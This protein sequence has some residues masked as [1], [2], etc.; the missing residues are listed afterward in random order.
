MLNQI[1]AFEQALRV[2]RNASAHTVRNYVSDVRQFNAFLVAHQLCGGDERGV[3]V[4][5]LDQMAV[6]AFLVDLLRRNRKSSAGRKLSAVKTFCRF[7]RR[8]G[9]IEHDPTAGVLTPKKD[10]QLPVHLTVDD[11]FRLLEAPRADTPDGVRDRALLEVVYSAG[12]RVSEL[13]GLD[14]DD[15]DP[16]LELVRVRGKGGKERIVPIG[17]KA[18]AALDTYRARI[19]Q[20]CRRLLEPQVVFL[21]RRGQR[22]TTR[23]VARL[24][25]H[26]ILTS[27]IATKASPHALRHSFATH[28]L[29]AG[30]DLRA[31]Q[32]LLGHASLSTTQ[33]YTHLNLD[34]LMAVY[35]KAHPRA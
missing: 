27:G 30:A 33:K 22:L 8:R 19:P 10:Q 7:L 5:Q 15:V 29:S 21:N 11:V 1:T 17:A 24:V 28:L 26:Y 18:L 25:D 34:H 6:R 9:V 16:K 2:E 23:S 20:L 12:L 14:W 31:I 35:D 4:Q 32:E 13:V 3:D